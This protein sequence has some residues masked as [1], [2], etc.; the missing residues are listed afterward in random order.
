M[1]L[2]DDLANDLD[3]PGL[4][5]APDAIA[6][7][8]ADPITLAKGL[9]VAVARPADTAAVA[10]VVR[11]SARHGVRITPRGG[12]S[13]FVA[14]AVPLAEAAPS[15]VLSL[16][17]MGR[18]RALDPVD[19]TMVVE[20][21]CILAAAREAAADAGLSLPIA[22][23]G[24]GSAMIGGTIATNAG[25][26]NVVRHGMTRRHVLGL[27]VVLADGR[28]WDGLRV[29]RKDN[30]GYDLK[31]LF[32]GSEGTLGIITAAALA[33]SPRPRA[34]ATG[35]LAVADPEAALA[36]FADLRR[37]LGDLIGAFE[38][39]P[40][41]ALALHFARRPQ[42]R[43]PL[44]AAPWL[45]LLEI[46]SPAEGLDLDA[47]LERALAATLEA[48]LVAD[49]ILA[50]SE[51]ER[52]ELW[53]LREG[54]AEAQATNPRVLKSDTS[55]PVSATA[56]FI[57][58]AGREV[59]ALMPGA[60]PVP[61]GHIGDGNI[62]FNVLAPPEMATEAFLAA[63]PDLTALIAGTSVALGGSIAAEHGIGRDKRA[64][65][66]R[67]RSGVERDLALGLKHLMDPDARLNP[68]K[69]V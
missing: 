19:E 27:E 25:G 49:A 37:R 58:T 21:G 2:L 17:R 50:R 40:R 4:L 47:L 3:A 52:A 55:V 60:T 23:G 30:A 22:H 11:T 57:A 48:G 65:L 38:L 24:A 31:Q 43:D 8:L 18:I 26:L 6:P 41:A 39:I 36:L 42:A 14:G 13:G 59:A 34:T 54:L 9:A 66:A 10:A 16:E 46:E 5:T 69:I 1:S 44:P 61:F 29:L 63:K 45:V 7:Y 51:R 20:A 53:S 35:L 33:L 28:V 62:H 15:L 67:V 32:I 12:G 56:A 68:G 64:L